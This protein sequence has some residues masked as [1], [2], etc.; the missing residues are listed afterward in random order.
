[1]LIK[2]R[3][4]EPAVHETVYVAPTAVLVG[5]IRIGPKSRVMYGAVLD[6][7]ASMITLGECSIVCANSVLRATGAGDAE[8]PVVVGDHVFISPHATLLGCTVERCS[9]IATG[10][11]VL[12]GARVQS[13]AAVAVGAFVHAGALVPEG[14]FV[15]PNMVAIG[16]PMKLYDSSDPVSLA[17]AVS[18]VEFAR[19]AF[20]A[21]AG[22]DD[23]LARYTQATEVR[24]EEFGAHTDDTVVG[25]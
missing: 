14:A 5:N 16:D 6:S 23:R 3:G 10:A 7:E 25:E 8:Y 11:T 18:S 13:G 2:H 22:W 4:H 21:S 15:P 12:Q 1:M 9:Y 17:E 19:R 24:S 20:G